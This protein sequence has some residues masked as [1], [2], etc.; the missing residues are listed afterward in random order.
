[1]PEASHIESLVRYCWNNEP[2]ELNDVN[3]GLME[4]DSNAKSHKYLFIHFQIKC[5]SLSP[6]AIKLSSSTNRAY[7]VFYNS[8]QACL[9]LFERARTPKGTLHVWGNCN[10]VYCTG[11]FQG[12]QG[13]TPG[14]MEAIAFV[15][16][17][18]VLS[19]FLKTVSGFTN[20]QRE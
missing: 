19:M 5:I 8:M 17:I 2:I 13:N 20:G 15:A 4:T 12:H 3:I 16:S 18:S 6:Q 11:A 10:L 7:S 14:G 9:L 1:M